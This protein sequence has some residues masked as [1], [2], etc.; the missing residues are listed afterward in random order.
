MTIIGH[1][2]KAGL[3]FGARFLFSGVPHPLI[4]MEHQSAR[5]E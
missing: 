2:E 1:R 5:S 4:N 3:F